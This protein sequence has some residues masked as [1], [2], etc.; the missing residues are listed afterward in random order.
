MTIKVTIIN[1]ESEGGKSLQ[2]RL[3]DLYSGVTELA[4]GESLEAFIHGEVGLVIA[5]DVP[6]FLNALIGTKTEEL[7]EEGEEE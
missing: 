1:S 5:E 4:P 3:G 2:Y 7:G 6:E